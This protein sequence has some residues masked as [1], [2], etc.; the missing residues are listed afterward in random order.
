MYEINVIFTLFKQSTLNVHFRKRYHTSF[1]IR[2][3]RMIMRLQTRQSLNVYV[4]ATSAERI[5]QRRHY[6]ACQ[7]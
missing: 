6:S 2:L 1:L 7:V 5:N 4:A 3:L